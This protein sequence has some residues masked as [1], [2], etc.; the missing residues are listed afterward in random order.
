[1]AMGRWQRERQQEL[2]IAT[3]Q[4][5]PTPRH[6]FYER[7][8][9]LLGQAGFDAWREAFCRPY[10]AEQGRTLIP[11]G[12]YF[13]MLMVGDF[14]D[15]DSQRGIAWRCADSLSRKTFLGVPVH[16]APPEHSSLTRITSRLPLEVDREVF[17]FVLK[18]VHEART[19]QGEDAGGGLDDAGGQRGDEVD[20]PPRQR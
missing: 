18:L 13:R 11:P 7:R 12:P 15:I 19:A 4:M 8:N 1:M 6:V 9:P 3:A 20:R 10:Y 5:S 14:E 16:A 17:A 2:W